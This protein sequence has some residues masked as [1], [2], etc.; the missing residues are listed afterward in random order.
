MK[1]YLR[2]RDIRKII[3]NVLNEA[4]SESF[5]FD[6]LKSIHSFRGRL[7]YGNYILLDLETWRWKFYCNINGLYGNVYFGLREFVNET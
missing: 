5:S 6:K 7:N 2:E 3:R 4:M 1:V